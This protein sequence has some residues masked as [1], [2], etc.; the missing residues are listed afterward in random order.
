MYAHAGLVAVKNERHEPLGML[1]R[2]HYGPLVRLAYLLTSDPDVAEDLVQEAFVRTWKAWG[3]LRD[4]EAA[5]FYL[6]RAVVNLAKSSLRRRR[7]ERRPMESRPAEPDP[8]IRVDLIRA[9]RT[10]PPRQ[11]ACIVM[12]YYA[13][14]SEADIASTLGISSGTVKSQTHKALKKLE[15]GL[16]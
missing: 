11:R 13:D 2:E 5:P 12:K 16:G 15:L 1:Y 6:R 3:K 9:V 8:S 7:V 4:K 14:M 10:L